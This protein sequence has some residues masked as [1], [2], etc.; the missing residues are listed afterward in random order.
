MDTRFWGPPAWVL[1]HSITY[2]YD[3]KL[4]NEYELFFTTIQNI[5]PCIYCRDS[6][7]EYL[8]RLPI[9]PFLLSGRLFEWLYRIHN[10]V[11]NKLR[12]QGLITTHNPTLSEMRNKYKDIT[13][14]LNVCKMREHSVMGWNFL[15]CIA[16]V[17]PEN[18]TSIVQTSHFSGYMIFFSLLSKLL[19]VSG[20]L[21]S[22]Y[23]K[24]IS[25]HSFYAALSCRDILKKWV[26]DLEKIMDKNQR[27][28]CKPLNQISEIIEQYRSGCG[29][30]KTD[31]Q[32]TCRRTL[33]T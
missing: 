10:M 29:G 31:T 24:Y 14:S 17:Y 15:Y 20:G 7:T 32:P 9:K 26:Y 2:L 8:E 16:F 12:Q 1:L 11:N 25:K 6:Y 19:P 27:V 4:I 13:E 18:G 21:R 30:K 28:E 5:L 3:P 33:S 22:V 23:N